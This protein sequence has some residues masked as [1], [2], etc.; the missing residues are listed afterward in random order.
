[1]SRS[2]G[3][4]HHQQPKSHTP[5]P[6]NIGDAET[7]PSIQESESRYNSANTP[8]PKPNIFKRGIAFMSKKDNQPIIANGLT[9]LMFVSTAFLVLYTI[10]LYNSSINANI[11]TSDALK[12][13]ITKDS[14]DNEIRIRKDTVDSIAES[15]KLKRDTDFINKQKIG[16]D[17]QIKAIGVNQNEFEIENRPFIAVGNMNT[18]LPTVG[19]KMTFS[20]LIG[21]A[22][23]QPA[24]IIDAKYEFVT[25]F[26]SLYNDTTHIKIQDGLKNDYI[27]N[28]STVPVFGE[29]REV[30]SKADS[31]Y[32]KKNNYYLYFRMIINYRGLDKKKKYHIAL[33]YRESIDEKKEGKTV[34][35]K[36]D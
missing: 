17:A 21:N 16:I 28:N 15:K 31:T 36:I 30:I 5:P 35:Y 29:G 26:D 23:K 8:K 1:M 24:F 34:L 22:G 6:I 14:N 3:T 33:I 4:R 25:S 20:A 11:T 19:K 10:G 9:L 27:P 32:L 13:Q 18:D 7:N 2:Q 12:H